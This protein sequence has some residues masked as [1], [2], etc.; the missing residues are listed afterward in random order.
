MIDVASL[1]MEVIDTGSNCTG[2]AGL[3]ARRP[4]SVPNPQE[5]VLSDCGSFL[6]LPGVLPGGVIFPGPIHGPIKNKLTALLLI[7]IMFTLPGCSVLLPV[8][9]WL[10]IPVARKMIRGGDD[11]EKIDEPAGEPSPVETLPLGD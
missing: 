9:K 10:A 6:A 8:A 5:F 4:N 7:A 1:E 3:D 2:T 11:G